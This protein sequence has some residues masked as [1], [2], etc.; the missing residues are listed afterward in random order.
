MAMRLKVSQFFVALVI[1]GALM[2]GAV[3]HSRLVPL[4][5]KHQQ[6]PKQPRQQPLKQPLYLIIQMRVFQV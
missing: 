5:P 4:P 2:L 3:L 1:V 6:Q